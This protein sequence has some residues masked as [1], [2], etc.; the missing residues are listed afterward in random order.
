M[1]KSGSS[2]YH[3]KDR[4]TIRGLAGQSG[5][6]AIINLPTSRFLHGR[7]DVLRGDPV[8]PHF[9]AGVATE[10]HGTTG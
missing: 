4:A 1:T 7:L 5:V 3:H 8:E 2:A 10:L 6:S 9:V